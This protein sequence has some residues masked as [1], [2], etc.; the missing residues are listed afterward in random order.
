ME[1]GKFSHESEGAGP[2]FRS[3]LKQWF[4][5]G[6][7]LTIPLFATLLVLA[8]ALDFLSGLLDPL[9]TVAV[10]GFGYVEE[11]PDVAGWVIKGLAV[12]AFLVLLLAVGIVAET[13][14]TGGRLTDAID[15][16][17]ERVPGIGSLYT[18]FRQMSE[19]VVE[20]DVES[21]QDVKL[22]EF[23]TEGSYTVAFVTADTPEN[24]ETIAGHDDMVTLFMPMAPN[25][26]MGGFVLHVSRERVL[27]VDMTVE[28][29]VQSI[30]TSGVTVNGEESDRKL[31][32]E[33]LR[34]LDVQDPP[35]TG[36]DGESPHDGE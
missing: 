36:T 15:R 6:A 18:G 32:P 8:F 11:Q 29:G 12:V 21:F 26:V 3:L 25:P 1:S 17:I 10:I 7:A 33:R 24:V 5:T 2:S 22:V 28:E 14:P 20:S 9:V 27:D 30:V 34:S 19:V 23:P 31:S 35:G 4:I 16:S 13:H